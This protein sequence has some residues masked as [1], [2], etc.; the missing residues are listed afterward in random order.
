MLILIVDLNTGLNYEISMLF[1][2]YVMELYL[3]PDE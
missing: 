1:S 2:K 3:D